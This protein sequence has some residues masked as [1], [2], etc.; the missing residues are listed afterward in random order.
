MDGS[1]GKLW[2]FLLDGMVD[3]CRHSNLVLVKI[4]MFNRHKTGVGRI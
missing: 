4:C 3:F 1:S 2:E